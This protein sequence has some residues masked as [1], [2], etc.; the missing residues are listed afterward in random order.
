MRIV[1]LLFALLL[2]HLLHA[3]DLVLD[4]VS[5]KVTIRIPKNFHKLKPEEAQRRYLSPREPL[6]MYSD[7]ANECDLV[8][9]N[10]NAFFDAKDMGIM[11]DFYKATLRSMYTKINFLREA[12]ETVGRRKALVFEFSSELLEKGR[13]TLKKYTYIQ[14]VLWGQRV[15]VCSFTCDEKQRPK[16]QAMLPK[17]M[18]SV[19]I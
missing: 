9:N 4:K 12:E 18:Q 13:P 16:Y 1:I 8:V 15:V 5:D 2:S 11:K 6:A 14:Y 3:Q 10:T 19:R 17:V 7:P